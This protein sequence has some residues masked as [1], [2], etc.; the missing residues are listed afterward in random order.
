MKS[1][2]L[3][4]NGPHV[5]KICFGA[6]PIGGG[7][8]AIDSSQAIK[9]IHTAIDGGINFIDTAEGYK[10]SESIL[11]K[12]II[13]KRKNLI[14]A[15]KLS[16]DDHSEKHIR[17]AIENSLQTLG[18]DYID[19]YQLHRPQSK[20]PISD[21]MASLLKLK[22]EGKIRYIGVSNHSISQT[23]E[24]MRYGEIQSSQPRY[25]MIFQEDE[26]ANL[27]F[28][29]DANIGIIPHSVLA[30]GLLTAKYKS[31]HSF[32]DDDERSS[33]LFFKGELFNTINTLV[34]KLDQWARDHNKDVIQLAIAWVLSNSAVSSAIVGM[35]TP[36][37]VNTALKA[38]EWLLSES[39]LS[40]ISTLIGNTNF[41]W[42][43]KWTGNL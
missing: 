35:K 13:G 21:T 8:G 31:N 25:N 14:L 41:K 29:K 5:S 16:G 1:S 7:M 32:P 33:F 4:L 10:N 27:E 30:K 9:T 34:L 28:C 6:W 23:K 18:T 17:S 3:G 19:V 11:G 24:A 36:S 2:T 39:N 37:Q 12:A 43:Q 22:D 20:W 26:T 15:T 40:E 38:S 42:H